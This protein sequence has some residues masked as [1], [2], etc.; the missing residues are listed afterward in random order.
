MTAF[1]IIH[2][3]LQPFRSVLYT[4]VRSRLK[5]IVKSKINR[6][7]VLDAGGRQ[8]RYTIGVKADITISDLHKDTD[9]QKKLNLGLTQEIIEK[10]HGKRSNVV[11]IVLDNMTQ[12]DLPDESFD[13][14][15]SVEVLEHVQEDDLF[16]SEVW[17]IL[18]PGGIFLMTTPNG[19]F[20]PNINPDHKRHY[21]RQQLLT[22][23]QSKFS[24]TQVEYAVPGGMFREFGMKAWSVRKPLQ[25]FLSLIGNSVTLL[26]SNNERV[27]DQKRRTHHLIATAKK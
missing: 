10:T 23:L 13:C 18:K 25:T 4:L 2:G 11:D 15:V 22:L 6:P 24:Q 16:V 8:S 1:E 26:R 3:S 7:K 17:R 9:I 19:D 12:S 20:V 14:I 27:K 21:T 5:Q